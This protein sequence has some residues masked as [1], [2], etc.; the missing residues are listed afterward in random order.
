MTVAFVSCTFYAWEYS[1]KSDHRMEI[2]IVSV[3]EMI[4]CLYN[5][6][7]LM[8]VIGGMNKWEA[9]NKKRMYFVISS[10][11]V[12]HRT[13]LLSLTLTV[14]GSCS[15]CNI[16]LTETCQFLKQ[17]D[18]SINKQMGRGT[19]WMTRDYK[20]LHGLLQWPI[21]YFFS[22]LHPT[23]LYHSVNYEL[24]FNSIY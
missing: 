4:L 7:K 2:L 21:E 16:L 14:L 20:P 3:I 12:S 22:K 15:F 17:E 18:R 6:V 19:K 8:S 24:M 9:L 13:L 23:A 10:L 11:P 1:M 5:E